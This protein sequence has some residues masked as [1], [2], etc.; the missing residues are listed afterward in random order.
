MIHLENP[1]QALKS[2][3]EI[4]A[5]GL[6]YEAMKQKLWSQWVIKSIRQN[7]QNIFHSFCIF[8]KYVFMCD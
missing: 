6:L 7:L 4:Q 2:H 3:D 5:L 8:V 1:W